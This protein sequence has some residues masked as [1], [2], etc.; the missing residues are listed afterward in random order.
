M[1][2]ILETD[3]RTTTQPA[4]FRLT[5]SSTLVERMRQ[6]SAFSADRAYELFEARGPFP[7]RLSSA[8][9]TP[10]SLLTLLNLFVRS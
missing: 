10:S 9:R 5:A 7:P 4:V 2:S 1:K 6:I 8:S 3:P